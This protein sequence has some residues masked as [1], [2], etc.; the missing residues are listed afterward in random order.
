MSGIEYPAKGTIF[1]PWERWRALRGVVEGGALLTGGGVS[2]AAVVML[3]GG[4]CSAVTG[5]SMPD[6][7]M[8]EG[9]VRRALTSR[10]EVHVLGVAFAA[11]INAL[12]ITTAPRAGEA[13]AARGIRLRN[14]VGDLTR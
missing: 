2:V 5:V 3:D 9:V 7:L 1:A 8:R 13:K 12:L 10:G 6:G 14:I 11:A 4:V